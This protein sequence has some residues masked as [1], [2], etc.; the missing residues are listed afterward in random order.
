MEWRAKRHERT[1]ATDHSEDIVGKVTGQVW[2]DETRQ[3]VESKARLKL[4]ATG[5]VLRGKKVSCQE[6]G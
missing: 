6:K 1:P 3:A 4:V 5:H 2:G